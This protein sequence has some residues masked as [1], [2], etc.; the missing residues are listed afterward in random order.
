MG[1]SKSLGNYWRLSKPRIWGLLVFTGVIAMVVAF[2]ETPGSTLT[3]SLL[4]KGTLALVLGSASADILTNYHDRDIDIMMKRTMKRAIPS[5]EIKPRNALAL[6]LT[7]AALSVL[8]PLLLINAISASFMLI[9]LL[10]NVVVYSLLLKRRSWLNIILGG[11]SGGMPVLVGYSAVAGTVT[12][13][14]LYMSALV[15]VWIP[16]H[17]WS[18]AIFTKEDYEAAKI[19]MLPVVFGNKIASICIAGTSA[20]LTV[21]SVAIFLFTPVSVFYTLTAITLG[22][23]V[24]VYSGKLA[25]NQS[26]KTAWTLFKFTSPY[27]T[28]IFLVLGL[29]VWLAS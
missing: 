2:K 8:I 12:P 18:L 17:I 9:G 14:A 6:G 24:L 23:V 27:L 15:I 21:F 4:V 25:L 1:L 3:A 11:I 20:L 26:S 5:G 7:M 10:D 13:I 28:I 16:T 22:G 19:P 29:T